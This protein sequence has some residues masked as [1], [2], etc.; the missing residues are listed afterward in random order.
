M[1]D[2]T[3]PDDLVQTQRDWHAAYHAL[4]A[5][6]PQ[7]TTALRR[8]LLRLSARIQR[9]PFWATRPAGTTAGRVELRHAARGW[10]GVRAA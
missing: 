9:H 8:R 3:F 10:S 2:H 5:P 1:D 6:G 4:A 7:N